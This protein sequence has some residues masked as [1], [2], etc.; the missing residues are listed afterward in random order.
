[1]AAS[2]ADR[3]VQRRGASCDGPARWQ[4]WLRALLATSWPLAP[5]PLDACR[6]R[7]G[8]GR[9]DRDGVMEAPARQLRDGILLLVHPRHRVRRVAVHRA[10][11]DG[12]AR[13]PAAAAAAGAPVHP[14]EHASVRG[15]GGGLVRFPRALVLR[16]GHRHP[17]NAGPGSVVVPVGAALRGADPGLVL[18]PFGA[19]HFLRR[20]CHHR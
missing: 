10:L 12:A 1:M 13:A 18:Q 4:S 17:G 9:R 11:A 16:E 20:V 3:G 8:R 2:E 14:T 19:D 7:G 15:P 6:P 5:P